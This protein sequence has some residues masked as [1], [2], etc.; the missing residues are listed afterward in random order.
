M[1]FYQMQVFFDTEK[2]RD[3]DMSPLFT[4][5]ELAADYGVRRDLTIYSKLKN[6]K[7]RVVELEVFDKEIEEE[8]KRHT[9]KVLPFTIEEL[10]GE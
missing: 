4:T 1:K 8:N 3:L 2:G 6:K 10:P 9:F 5:A 7:Y